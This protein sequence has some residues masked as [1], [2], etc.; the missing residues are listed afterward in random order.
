MLFHR[1]L[2]RDDDPTGRREVVALLA[3]AEDEAGGLMNPRYARLRPDM[4][5]DE[6]ISYVRR[7]TRDRV[8]T[9]YYLYVLSTDQCLEGVISFRELFLARSDACVRDVMTTDVVTVPEERS[10]A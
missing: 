4:S 9:I 7:Q 1:N 3:Y 6:A 5:V 8:E 2:L 10:S